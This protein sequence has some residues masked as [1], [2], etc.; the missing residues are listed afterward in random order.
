MSSVPYRRL[1]AITHI[2]IG[3]SLFEDEVSDVVGSQMLHQPTKIGLPRDSSPFF[4]ASVDFKENVCP[5]P[6]GIV[7]RHSKFWEKLC[8]LRSLAIFK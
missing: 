2:V 8:A 4:T 6:V 7:S 3:R 1:S 5:P